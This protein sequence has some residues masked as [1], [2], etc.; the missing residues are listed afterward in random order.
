M[1]LVQEARFLTAQLHP[2]AKD[3]YA[4][5]LF[6]GSSTE[7]DIRSDSHLAYGLATIARTMPDNP[8]AAPAKKN[9]IAVLRF[10]LQT[11]GAGGS[12]CNDGKQWHNQWQSAFWAHSAGKA[13]W[14]LWDD[15]DPKL[16]FLAARMIAEEA[17]RFIDVT[18]PAQVIDDTKAEENAWDSMVISLAAAMFPHHPHHAK[19]QETAIRWAV[20]SYVNSNDVK[21]DQIID[22]R[23]LK[24]WLSKPNIHEDYTLENHNRVHP[25]YMSNIRLNLTQELEYGW[26]A[27]KPPAALRFNATNVYAALEKLDFPDGGFVY[28][29]GQDWHLH[30]ADFFD[31]HTM[32]ALDFNDPQAARMMRI[33]LEEIEKMQAR[34]ADG[35][36]SEPNEVLSPSAHLI[37]MEEIPDAYFHLRKYGDG[38]TP[39]DENELWRQLSGKHLFTFGKFA[40]L[41]TPTSVATFS[42]GRQVMG[43]VLPLRKDLLLSPNDRSLIGNI[44]IGGK[45]DTPVVKFASIIPMVKTLAVSGTLDRAGGAMSQRFAFVALPDG[46]TVYVDA[47]ERATAKTQATKI[48]LGLLGI[49]NEPEWVYQTAS[50]TLDF[51]DGQRVFHAQRNSDADYEGRS[52]WYCIDGLGILCLKATGTQ[53]FY[54]KPTAA[55]GRREQSFV[56]NKIDP[57][58]ADGAQTA[59]VFYPNV[60]ADRAAKFARSCKLDQ[61]SPLRFAITLDDGTTIDVDLSQLTVN[62]K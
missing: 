3:P 4:L 16:Q 32:M 5:L 23:P 19:W 48:D 6:K 22:G 15:L 9:A 1:A 46:R 62:C 26:G 45:R 53:R 57:E 39:V 59:L 8:F 11:H 41:R 14:L 52:P 18:P 31:I 10:L 30:R 56:L 35:S 61:P 49:L 33:C 50:R 28:P 17:D 36:I 13:A 58:Q 2:W 60:D 37:Q 25:D 21:S 24:D 51:A 42:W 29:N 7:Q 43:M 44:E 27:I 12:T 54:G 34:H 38:P 55:R 40:L 47:L 20:S